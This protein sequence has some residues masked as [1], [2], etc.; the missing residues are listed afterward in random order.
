MGVSSLAKSNT[1]GPRIPLFVK[2][3]SPVNFSFLYFGIST[4]KIAFAIVSAL[5]TAKFFSFVVSGIIA[6]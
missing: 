2:I 6:G 4:F 5:Q 1:T 3:K